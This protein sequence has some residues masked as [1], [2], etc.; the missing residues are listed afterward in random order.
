M[1]R[2][3]GSLLSKREWSLLKE[4]LSVYHIYFHIFKCK[5]TIKSDP[6]TGKRVGD[7]NC[8]WRGLDAGFSRQRFQGSHYKH[9]QRTKE[10]HV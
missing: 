3:R 8:F 2:I 9:A 10:A 1:K 5:E 6:D 7:R 4:F